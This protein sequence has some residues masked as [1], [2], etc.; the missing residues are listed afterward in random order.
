MNI[1]ML[2]AAAFTLVSGAAMAQ[3]APRVTPQGV[4]VNPV[5]TALKVNVSLDKGGNNPLYIEGEK[6]RISVRVNQD[7]YV[8]VFD[9]QPNG[10]VS[11]LLPNGFSGGTPFLRANETRTFPPSGAG[12]ELTISAPYGQEKILALAS[13]RQL[14][15]SAI[16]PQ[17]RSGSF[18]TAT[19][20]GQEGLARALSVTVTPLP[21]QDWVTDTADFQTR[22]KNAPAANGALQVT[23]NVNGANVYVDGVLVGRTPLTLNIPAGQHTVRVTANG[24]REDTTTV[25][26]VG[27]QTTRVDGSLEAIQQNG[28]LSV[29][30][31]PNVNA[32]VYLDGVLIGRGDVRVNVPAGQHTVRVTA[33]GY[34]EFQQT[35]NVSNGG[36]TN[37]SANLVQ[38][39]QNGRLVVNVN[40]NNANVYVDGVLVGRGDL[41]INIPAGAH[42][43]KVTLDGFETFQ[44]NITVQNGQTTTIN[45][46]LQ[47]IVQDGTLVVRS[48]VA[49][50]RV[51]VNGNEVGTIGQDGSLTVTGLPAGS[52]EVTVVAPGF[53][54]FVSNFNINGGQTTG[55]NANLSRI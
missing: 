17:V 51:F 6:Q 19:V 38:I 8:Y 9:I 31:S 30:V 5:D 42:T 12:Y 7:A 28:S 21:P 10:Q 20:Q 55:V 54:S 49:G 26:V 39:Q 43:V 2:L 32:N 4:I 37:V 53:R 11:V 45:V 33:S 36:Q 27:G 52:H 46:N 44:Q 35:I 13:K 50:A 34:Q 48:N 22:A 29:N 15:I 16:V 47:P 1:K 3:S 23:S 24:Y 25:N 40:S 41:S 18:V 14:E